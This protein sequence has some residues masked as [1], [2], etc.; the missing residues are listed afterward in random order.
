ML[1]L[2]LFSPLFLEF[3]GYFMVS[4]VGHK[5]F[6][7]CVSFGF[8]RPMSAQFFVR[9]R[10]ARTWGIGFPRRAAV[11]LFPKSVRVFPSFIRILFGDAALASAARAMKATPTHRS[12]F[13]LQCNMAKMWAPALCK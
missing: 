10:L 13:A 11:I 2:W 8:E 3:L 12:V 7:S 4:L 6:V 1:V 5:Q 9:I